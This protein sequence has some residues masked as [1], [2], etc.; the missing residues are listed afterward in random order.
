M[1][2]LIAPDALYLRPVTERHRLIFYLGHFD[3]FDWNLLATR[4]LSAASFHPEFDRLFERGI[5]PAPGQ[6]S[7]D[8]P[9]D[10]P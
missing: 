8:T 6:A 2:G 10:W 9:A 7:S 5:D 3:A 4:G 1:F